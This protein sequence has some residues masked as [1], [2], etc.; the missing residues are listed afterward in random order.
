MVYD[1]QL[2]VRVDD[3]LAKVYSGAIHG[4]EAYPVE[5]ETDVS[6]GI[7]AVV[8]VGLPDAAVKESRDR[9][10]TAIQNSGFVYPEGRL[11]IN[12]APADIKKEGPSFDLP[13]AVGILAASKQIGS[14]RLG[15]FSFLGELALDG[16]IR[17]VRGVL[18]ITLAA[19]KEGRKGIIVPPDNVAEAAVVEGIDVYPVGSLAAL[20]MFLDG[21]SKIAAVKLD[22]G[23]VFTHARNYPIDF[24]DVKG[25]AHV[26][27]AIEVAAA[28]GHNIIMIGP[29]GSGKTM[30]AKRLPT[31][32]PEMTIDEAL[33]TTKIHSI[34]GLLSPGTSLAATRPFRNPHHSISD[35]GLIGGGTYPR[36]GEVSLAHNGTLFLD[37]LPE[38]K[39][40]VLELLRQP[41]EDGHVN[42]SRASGTITYP[43]RFLLAAAMNPCPCGFFTDPQRTCRC[44][45]SQIQQ[46]MSKISGPLLDR[47]DIHVEVPAVKYRELAGETTGECS[48]AMRGRVSRARERQ[49]AR[50]GEEKIHCNAEMSHR[51][52]RKHC[53]LNADGQ[54][55]LKT[56]ITE[57]GLSARAYDRVLKVSRTIADLEGAGG[58]LPP[59][60]SEA[61]QY[62]V[63]DRQLWL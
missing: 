33:E 1:W 62:R 45:P 46:Y 12:L 59:H 55:L 15:D 60:V 42:I 44:T 3:M 2:P 25:Q 9:V 48:E 4:V 30:L 16:S 43:A 8:I 34:A 61:I 49:L 20:V 5:I 37:E 32:I 63:L 10:K 50:F 36:P 31:I 47:I 17:A 26:K 58:I 57:L 22:M 52:I 21:E 54:E 56:A 6:G 19:K 13:I 53:P 40:N 7:P 41:I 24:S 23:E 39:R 28:G 14:E 51:Q 18:P 35:A 11:T 27:R 38:F 29:P